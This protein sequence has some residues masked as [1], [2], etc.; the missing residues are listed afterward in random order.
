MKGGYGMS[1]WGGG[2]SRHNFRIGLEFT[3]AS[4]KYQK[5]AARIKWCLSVW[6]GVQAYK[7]SRCSGSFWTEGFK[8]I[9][10]VKKVENS[11][12]IAFVKTRLSNIFR[13]VRVIP[14]RVFTREQVVMS[15]LKSSHVQR[16]EELILTDIL[17]SPEVHI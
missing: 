7:R 12:D 16:F 8:F 9:S 17:N 10:D 15:A 2:T 14:E 5:A 3:L 1:G 13:D 6:D 11:F 4:H